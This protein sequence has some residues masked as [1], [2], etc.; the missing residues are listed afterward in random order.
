MK[1]YKIK[2]M[3]NLSVL[4]FIVLFTSNLSAQKERTLTQLNIGEQSIGLNLG[5]LDFSTL[6]TEVSYKRGIALFD[7][8]FIIGSDLAIPIFEPDFNDLRWRVVTL[9]KSVI[10]KGKFDMSIQF[11]PMILL[12]KTKVRKSFAFGEH[13]SVMSGFYGEKWGISFIID[14]DFINATKVK[15]TDYYKDVVYADVYDGWLQNPA[16]NLRLSLKGTRKIGKLETSL[17]LGYGGTFKNAYALF[18]PFSATIGLR[19]VF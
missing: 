10:R 19:Y 18:P 2:K 3:K 17:A 1:F 11:A 7:K 16:N 6:T 4:I 15:H 5:V 9:Q 12:S 8:T 14:A 13:L